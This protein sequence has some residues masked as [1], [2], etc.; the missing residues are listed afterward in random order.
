MRVEP[1]AGPP[2]RFRLGRQMISELTGMGLGGGFS[3]KIFLA[4]LLRSRGA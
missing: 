1:V 4:K 3:E 2:Q